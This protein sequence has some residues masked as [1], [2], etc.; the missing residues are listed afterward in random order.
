MRTLV[1]MRGAP[2]SGKSTFIKRM[3]LKPYTISPDDF[4][5]LA[6]S[7][8]VGATGHKEVSQKVNDFVWKM[9]Y[10]FL[11][12]RMKKGEFTIIDATAARRS[13]INNYRNLAQKY[14]YKTYVVDLSNEKIEDCKARNAKRDEPYRVPEAAIDKMYEDFKTGIPS[15]VNVIK[16]EQFLDVNFE[17]IDLSKYNKI[18]HIGD[19]HGCIK[20]LAEFC[21]NHWAEDEALIFCGDYL[22]RGLN[23]AEVLA[24]IMSI[25]DMPNVFFLEG[26]HEKHLWNWA[27]DDY[28]LSEE[29]REHTQKQLEAAGISKKDVRKFCR[30][31]LQCAYYT[32]KR[33]SVNAVVTVTHGGI[34]TLPGVTTPTE[35]YIKGNGYYSES[36]DCDGMFYDTM[37][38]VEKKMFSDGTSFYSVHGHRNRNRQPIRVNDKV[39]NLEGEVEFGGCLRIATLSENG[40][41]TEEIKNDDFHADYG[42]LNIPIPNDDIPRAIEALRSTRLIKENKMGKDG[43][44]SSFNFSREAFCDNKWTDATIKSRGLFINTETNKVVARGYEKF[45]RINQRPETTLEALKESLVFPVTGYKKYDGFLG[46]LGYDEETDDFVIASKSTTELD[47]AGYFKKIFNDTFCEYKQKKLKKYLKDNNLGMVFEVIDPKNDRH[48]IEYN[49]TK[50]ILLDILD[51][52]IEFK[53]LPYPEVQRIAE[54]YGIMCKERLVVLNNFNEFEDLFNRLTSVDYTF[55]GE[56]I[57]GFV[58][59]DANG[60]MVKGKTGY[61]DYWHYLRAVASSVIK[62]GAIRKTEGVPE[63]VL[64]FAKWVLNYSEELI[65][66]N[67]LKIPN[68]EYDT[69][70]IVLRR[71]YLK[72][73]NDK[74]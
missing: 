62:N 63:D 56:Y 67:Q 47:F 8:V 26:N 59:E 3:G 48:I 30:K 70:I 72:Y 66:T 23:N 65:D 31:L 22:D 52:N 5:L 11:E 32:Y 40:W 18:H 71:E 33:G 28:V 29:F 1:L 15:W 64:A 20:P 2:G 74:T 19:V 13:V 36:D 37:S 24:F 14:R 34:N 61:H 57:E 73:L 53:K 12:E 51:R 6:A 55:N 4:R 43:H 45:F 69:N 41:S 42:E 10:E 27:N 54:E 21:S 46:I 58:F 7:P 17:T 44:I 16:P 60:F 39:F 9:T 25:A 38:S 50:I 35:T 49:E 68:K